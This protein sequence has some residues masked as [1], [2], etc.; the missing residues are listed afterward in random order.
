MWKNLIYKEWIKMR[1][2]MLL[3]SLFGLLVV[4]YIILRVRSG[5]LAVGAD[6]LWYSVLFNGYIYFKLLIFVPA[7]IA[8]VATIAQYYPETVNKRIKLT[9]HLPFNENRIL[10]RMHLFGTI[11][12]VTTYFLIITLF[13][14]GSRLFFPFEIVAGSFVTILPWFMG[15]FVIYFLGALVILEPLWR[16]KIMYAAVSIAFIFIYYQSAPMSG[17]AHI[18]WKL[19]ILTFC[20]MGTLLFSGYRFRKGEM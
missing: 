20:L 18:I 6:S 15:G 3:S 7:L 10:L 4:M 13:L 1:W 9:F 17:Y 12:L 19:I 8:L 2:A 16:F 5:I 11:C 14:I